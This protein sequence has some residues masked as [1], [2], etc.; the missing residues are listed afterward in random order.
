MYAQDDVEVEIDRV[1]IEVV[2]EKKVD[3]ITCIDE[4]VL[5]EVYRRL[6]STDE[7]KFAVEI[8]SDRFEV[9]AALERAVIDRRDRK[10]CQKF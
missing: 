9:Y 5:S 7:L 6:W 1:A 10:K 8:Y 4:D 3:E 2:E